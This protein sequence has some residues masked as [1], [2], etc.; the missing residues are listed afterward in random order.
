MV[1][2]R[3]DLLKSMKKVL[4]GLDNNSLLLAGA[5][6][7]LF[8][9]GKLHTYNDAICVTVDLEIEGKGLSLGAVKAVEFFKLL[10]K[11]NAD[12]VDIEPKGNYWRVQAG[13][14]TADLN[15]VEHD[16]LDQKISA[17]H[18]GH[19]EWKKLPEDFK[20]SLRLVSFAS[21]RS[22]LS[23]AFFAE[24]AVYGTDEVRINRCWLKGVKVQTFWISDSSV[25]ELS[26]QDDLV[27]YALSD[28]WAHFRSAAGT[29]FSCKRLDDSEFPINMM[30]KLLTEFT[31]V[32][33]D[34]FHGVLPE[35]LTKAVERA[36][37]F[38][39]AV[40][41]FNAVRLTFKPEG[42]EVFSKRA[43]GKFS[44]M[45][46]WPEGTVFKEKFAPIEVYVD[47]VMAEYA[48]ARSKKFHLRR[49]EAQKSTRMVFTGDQVELL[50]GTI[51]LDEEE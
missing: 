33:E 31:D 12:L 42:I 46:D 39:M 11:L 51:I 23:G 34:D 38:S 47:F 26:K 15:L 22:K 28:N 14:V 16:E 8:K 48:L 6:A 13:K 29:M 7:F 41:S 49:S 25:K 24:D 32:R 18:D 30:K 20:D 36:A 50:L 10:S 43:A 44:E 17:V 35:G 19:W 40:E 9:N 37:T 2:N 1:V 21:N 4:P 27:E 3:T 45:V 5:D